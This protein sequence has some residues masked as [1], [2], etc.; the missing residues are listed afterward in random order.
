MQ[1]WEGIDLSRLVRLCALGALVAAAGP[2]VAAQASP[3]AA[4]FSPQTGAGVYD[5]GAVDGVA[6]K[7]AEQTFH[8]TNLGASKTPLLHIQIQGSALFQ[9]TRDTCKGKRLAPGK[10]CLVRVRYSPRKVSGE[11]DSA[12]M[13][14]AGPTG[15]AIASISLTG[16]SGAADLSVSPATF[17]GTSPDGNEYASGLGTAPSSQT[18][19]LTNNGTGTT[20]DTL[21]VVPESD[22]GVWGMSNDACSGG[23]LAP[24][25]SCTFDVSFGGSSGCPNLPTEQVFVWGSPQPGI[26]SANYLDLSLYGTC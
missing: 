22:E 25:A 4:A 16:N 9:K 20:L 18:F 21:E 11:T 17:E 26:I 3:P 23:S 24:G 7:R 1:L 5:F 19:T 12:T 14:A 15:A 8:L 10:S 13:V 2:V 6:G